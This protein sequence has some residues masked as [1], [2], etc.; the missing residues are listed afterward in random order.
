MSAVNEDDK[1]TPIAPP[2]SE[3]G[4][5]ILRNVVEAAVDMIPGAGVLT[6]VYRT[7]FPA[8]SGRQREEWQR[9]ISERTNDHGERLDRH[10]ALLF[11][12]ARTFSGPTAQLIEAVAKTC[13]DGLAEHPID[14]EEL[15]RLVP[16]S[17]PATVEDAAL[18]L[19]AAGLLHEQYLVGAHRFRPTQLFYEQFDHQVM[20]W[21][22]GST[23]CDAA[24]IAALM[25]EHENGAAA[26]LHELTGWPLRRFNPALAHL[27]KEHSG[28]VWRPQYHF[29]YPTAG[30]AI[31]R[32]EKVGLRRFVDTIERE[33]SR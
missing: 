29:E 25:I 11:P 27:M 9:V 19:S 30:L 12:E 21:G 24:S 33:T 32:L 28:W 13:P 8:R 16:G 17:D 14:I 6:A 31:N 2:A 26:E 7:T 1:N 15:G 22:G 18:E 20:G 3:P 23:R 4:R 5:E 10:E